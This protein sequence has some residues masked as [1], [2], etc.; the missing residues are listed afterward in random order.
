MKLTIRA[1][2]K[3]D[4]DHLVSVLDQWWGGAAG[5]RAHPVF[6]YEFG[7]DALIAERDGEVVGFLLGFRSPDSPSYG[8]VHFV[9]I[10]PEFRRRGVGQELYRAFSERSLSAGATSLKAIALR[11][12]E[13][14]R[15]FH[16]ALGFSAEEDPNYAGPGRARIVFRKSLQAESE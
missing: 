12:D 8:Y 15:R 16:E 4:Y 13:G 3:A 1:M 2:A 6:F 9:G 5:Q 10:H 14:A 11:G 7:R